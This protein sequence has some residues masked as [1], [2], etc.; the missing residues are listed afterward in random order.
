MSPAKPCEL[1][2]VETE[3]HLLRAVNAGAALGQAV[4][5]VAHDFA[6]AFSLSLKYAAHSPVACSITS[7]GGNSVMP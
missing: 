3:M 2:A 5:L 6:S 1:L 4:R 7:R